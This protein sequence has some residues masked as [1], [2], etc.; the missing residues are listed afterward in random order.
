MDFQ[1]VLIVDDEPEICA[2]LSIVIS[3]ANDAP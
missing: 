3:A 2:Q 1:T